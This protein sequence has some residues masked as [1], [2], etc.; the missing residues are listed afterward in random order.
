MFDQTFVDS[1][2]RTGTRCAVLVSILFE[3]LLVGVLALA[4]LLFLSPL[5]A[6]QIWSYVAGPPAAPSRPPAAVPPRASGPR[7]RFAEARLLAPIRIPERVALI[8]DEAPPDA[9]AG[10]GPAAPGVPGALPLAFGGGFP[11]LVP[12]PR[13]AAPPSAQPAPAAK[14]VERP[15]LKIGGDVQKAKLLYGP[16][17]AYPPLARQNR[18]S[19]MVR[20]NAVIGKDGSVRELRV[21]SG[22]P[23]FVRPALEAV[24][25]WRYRPTLLNGE[26]VE[27]ITE[28][29]VHFY[30]TP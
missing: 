10:L 18:I 1:R 30:L 28:I 29:D 15:R 22:H 3:C 27:V 2:S 25:Q 19:G 11:V 5:P 24:S 8:Q 9:A 7:R 6:R 14:P 26:P 4:P 21:A 20:L 23:F 12:A 17:P 16:L 13:P